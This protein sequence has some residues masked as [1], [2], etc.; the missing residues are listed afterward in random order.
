MFMNT[1]LRAAV[2]LGKDYDTNLR[3]VEQENN[4]T[5][6]QGNRK[7][8]EWSD[9]NHWHK[10]DQFPRFKAGIDKLHAQSSLSIFHCQG[11][12]LLRLCAL[13]GK[14]GNQSCWILEEE[15]SMVFG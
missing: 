10:P 5:P 15:N 7:A 4:R 12:C 6:F 14:N 8:D 2:H 11:L 13:P 3:F 9:R 1:T